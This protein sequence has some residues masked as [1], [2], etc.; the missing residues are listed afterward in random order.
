L[1]LQVS[2]IFT[3]ADDGIRGRVVSCDA[4]EGDTTGGMGILDRDMDSGETLG[5]EWLMKRHG[6]CSKH[7]PT[8][9]LLDICSMCHFLPLKSPEAR[10][11]L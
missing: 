8:C 11:S 7:T 2:K 3:L 5:M 9:T 1:P 10:M 6:G 4:A